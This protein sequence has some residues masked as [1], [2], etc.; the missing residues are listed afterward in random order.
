MKLLQIMQAQP[1]KTYPSVDYIKNFPNLHCN[2]C[3]SQTKSW[4][5]WYPM[6]NSQ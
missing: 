4:Y 5:G 2:L 1:T 6:L 3:S